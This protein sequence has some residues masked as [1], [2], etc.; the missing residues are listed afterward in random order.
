MIVL[1]M[2]DIVRISKKSSFYTGNE[3]NPINIDG[4]IIRYDPNDAELN[5][6]ITVKWD[7]GGSNTYCT[8]DLRLRR[9]RNE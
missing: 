9:R 7:N 3:S 8:Y 2:H 1:Q 5:H 6:G 4:K